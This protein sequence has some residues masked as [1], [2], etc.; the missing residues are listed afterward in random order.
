MNQTRQIS[1]ATL[2]TRNSTANE[3]K[4]APTIPTLDFT[5]KGNSFSSVPIPKQPATKQPPLNNSLSMSFSTTSF[6]D[7]NDTYDETKASSPFYKAGSMAVSTTN[8]ESPT[9][10]NRGNSAGEPATA[11][12]PLHASFS[13]TSTMKP[14]EPIPPNP[15]LRAILDAIGNRE[16]TV[17]KEEF[18]QKA[19]ERVIAQAFN[20]ALTEMESNAKDEDFRR[21]EERKL[22]EAWRANENQKKEKIHEKSK[23]LKDSLD[24]QLEFSKTRHLE[25]INDRKNSMA[26]FILPDTAGVVPLSMVIDSNTGKPMDRRKLISTELR[27]QIEKNLIENKQKKNESV[28]K[29]RDLINK[30]QLENELQTI[31]QRADHLNK[32]KSLLEA[33]EQDGHL[34]NLKKLQNYGKELVTDYIDRNLV[35]INSTMNTFTPSLNQSLNMSIGYDSRMGK[36]DK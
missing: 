16:L 26:K 14:N 3:T 11:S 33:W 6:K 7:F 19:K 20:R 9:S 24:S 30:I 18:R 31:I 28:Q 4:K 23:Q 36:F 17:G 25:E 32:Q 12:S 5:K 8:L 1:T 21:Y 35:D 10:Y 22:Y 29:E 27:Q 13:A 34:R 2:T 15:E